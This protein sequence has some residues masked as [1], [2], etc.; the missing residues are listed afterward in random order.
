MNTDK[1]Q[2]RLPRLSS[3]FICVHLWLISL[4][5]APG[6]RAEN[7]EFLF[8]ASNVEPKPRTVHLAGD[9]N[10]WSKV[11]TPMVDSGNGVFK[12]TVPLAEGVHYYKF[13]LDGEK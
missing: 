2:I 3:V 7:H 1:K 11:A 5:L 10:G 12:V 4:L 8:D 13:V 9:F 6:A